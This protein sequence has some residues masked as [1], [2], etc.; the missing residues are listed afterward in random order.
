MLAFR[1][2][3]TYVANDTVYREICGKKHSTSVD[4]ILGYCVSKSS[5]NILTVVAC[6]AI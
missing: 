6:V 4:G 2:Q 5:N 1:L 3:I